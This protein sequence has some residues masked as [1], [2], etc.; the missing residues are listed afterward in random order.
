MNKL[1]ELL[2][3]LWIE[4][5]LRASPAIEDRVVS[6][7]HGAKDTA[8]LLLKPYLTVWQWRGHNEGGPLTVSYAG[9]GYAASFLESILFVGEPTVA[10]VEKVP[11]WRPAELA[12]SPDSDLIIIEATRGLVEKLPGKKALILPFHVGLMLDIQGS[13]EEVS[14]RFHR[15]VRKYHSRLARKYGYDYEVSYDDQDLE[16]FYHAMYLPTLMARYPDLALPM[17]IQEAYQYFRHGMLFLIKRDGQYVSG[18]LCSVHNGVV[19]RRSLGV[20]NADERLL[21][22]GAQATTHYA[23]ILWANQQGVAGRT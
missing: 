5:Q 13:W 6:Y 21:Q 15:S 10:E 1:F 14:D 11:V 7:L 16:M 18:A 9:L 22:E 20:M 4:A 12:N 3:W 17:S 2:R 23:S 19:N 8:R